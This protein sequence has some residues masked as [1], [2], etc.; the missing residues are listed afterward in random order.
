MEYNGL[1]TNNIYDLVTYALKLTDINLEDENK[2]IEKENYR[3][4]L[5]NGMYRNMTKV[6]DNFKKIGIDVDKI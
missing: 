6:N 2:N 5:K 1:F 3:F 4:E